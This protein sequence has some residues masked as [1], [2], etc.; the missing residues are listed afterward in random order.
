LAASIAGNGMKP[1]SLS[2]WI[3]IALFACAA[4]PLCLS[5]YDHGRAFSD[6]LTYH[7]PAILHFAN[8]GD[9]RDYSSATTPGFHLLLAG[10]A[11]WISDTERVLKVANFLI[12]AAL[13]GLLARDLTARLQRPRLSIVMLLPVVFSIYIFPSGVWLLPDNLAW[14]CVF[15]VLYLAQHYNHTLRWHVLTCLALLAAVFVRQTNLWLSLVVLG[16]A[17]VGN[18][19]QPVDAQSRLIRLA[20]A[21][22]ACLPAAAVLGYFFALWHGMTPPAF[23]E[24]HSTLNLAALPFFLCL[25][26]FYSAFYL[27][28]ALP[29]MRQM[30][31]RPGTAYAV[32]FGAVAGLI[33]ALIAPTEW[34]PEAGRVS[35]LWNLARVFPVVQHRSLSISALAVLGGATAA[36]W[37]LMLARQTRFIAGSAVVGF[38]VSQC[39]SHFVYERYYAGF[40]FLLILL[41]M[42]DALR[43]CLDTPTGW[44][45]AAP[46]TF[47]VLN[48]GILA[49]GL[50]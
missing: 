43:G 23:A 49:A 30:L 29:R 31:S 13:L 47:A 27:P 41:M 1:Q 42:G 4:L 25:L 2:A 19:D 10:V 37:W 46:L 21:V 44:R 3:C 16:A 39:A 35:G 11:A 14:L 34:D 50:L 6:Q 20:W 12:T 48:A 9:F 32:T 40:I 5:N 38:V 18:T 26:C 28:L 8:G 7:Y 36:V 45:I 17:W 33:I 15:A 24:K 22:A